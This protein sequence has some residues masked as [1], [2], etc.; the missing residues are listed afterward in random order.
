MVFY[1]EMTVIESLPGIHNHEDDEIVEKKF[2]QIL[3]KPHAI[4][5][6]QFYKGTNVNCGALVC[7]N[8]KIAV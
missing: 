3:Q 2:G 8:K 1:A 6:L 5:E 4:A 7:F